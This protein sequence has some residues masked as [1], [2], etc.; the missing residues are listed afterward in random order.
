MRNNDQDGFT[1]L[2]TMISV[3]LILLLLGLIVQVLI[4]WT[5]TSVFS[6]NLLD[7]SSMCQKALTAIREDLLQ[8]STKVTSSEISWDGTT[9]RFKVAV[10]SNPEGTTLYSTNPVSYTIETIPDSDIKRIKKQNIDG[11]EAIVGNYI[12]DWTDE[13]GD[14]KPGFEADISN[15]S[16]IAVTV[17]CVKGQS[18]DREAVVTRTIRVLPLNED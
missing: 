14:V 3:T 17:T 6:S 1:L 7:A 2:E 10:G 18:D 4:S 15:P 13:T 5:R 12:S 16:N 8:S 11:T 9:L